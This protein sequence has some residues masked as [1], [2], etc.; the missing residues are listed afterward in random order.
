M[1]IWILLI[2]LKV[3]KNIKKMSNLIRSQF[4]AHPFHLV[5]PSPWPIFTCISLLTL[6]TT[7][8]LTMHGFNNVEYFLYFA[9]FTLI[10]SMSFWFRDV[11]SEGKF[12]YLL[13]INRN[14]IFNNVWLFSYLCLLFIWYKYW[15]YILYWWRNKIN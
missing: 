7:G 11:I 9:L 4:Q 2:N 13:H 15:A 3:K 6:T 8:V 12:I 1:Y 10:S 14:Y 5:S